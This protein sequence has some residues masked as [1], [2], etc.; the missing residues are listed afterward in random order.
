[1]RSLDRCTFAQKADFPARHNV[2]LG[3]KRTCTLA[4]ATSALDWRADVSTNAQGHR[5]RFDDR[6]SAQPL[7]ICCLLP[8]VTE[9]PIG[10][11]TSRPTQAGADLLRNSTFIISHA[12]VAE[13]VAERVKSQAPRDVARCRRAQGRT[14]ARNAAVRCPRLVRANGCPKRANVDR[15]E[16]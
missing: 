10:L 4:F 15:G 5:S 9:R 6:L 13:S 16:R 8:M 14:E 2:R 12:G 11:P 1:M 3:H 7:W